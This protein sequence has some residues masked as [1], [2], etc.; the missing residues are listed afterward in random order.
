MTGF[1]DILE[2][3]PPY[4]V[5]LP[6]AAFFADVDAMRAVLPNDTP[7]YELAVI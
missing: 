7:S 4:I 5:T 3:D 1:M 2:I 6:L